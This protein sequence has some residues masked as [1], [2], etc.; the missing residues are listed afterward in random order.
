M[1]WETIEQR[2]WY[3]SKRLWIGLGLSAGLTVLALPHVQRSFREWRGHRYVG[4]AAAASA[5]GQFDEA[6]LNARAALA[7]NARDLEALRVMAQSLETMQSPAAL[8]VRR[9]IDASAPE[10]SENLLGMAGDCLKAGDAPG[11][12]LA[13]SRI[14]PA[15]RGQA[16]YYDAQAGIFLQRGLPDQADQALSEAVKL[17]PK[18]DDYRLRQAA[19][20]LRSRTPETR[21]EALQT[22]DQLSRTSPRRLFALRTLLE[23]AT[24]HGDTERAQVLAA[25]VAADPT[26]TFA[27]RLVRLTALRMRKGSAFTSYSDLEAKKELFDVLAETQQAAGTK[28]GEIADLMNWMN[29]HDLALMVPDWEAKLPAGV[30]GKPPVGIVVAEA[31]AKGSAWPA[32]RK[33]LEKASWGEAEFLRLAYLA[34]CLEWEKEPGAEALWSKAVTAA[35]G[36]AGHLEL[37]AKTALGWD[38]EKRAGEVLWKLAATDRCPRWALDRLWTAAEKAQDSEQLYRVSKLLLHADPKSVPVRNSYIILALLTGHDAESS[39]QLAASLARENPGDEAVANTY[40]FSLYKEGKAAEAVRVMDALTPAQLEKPPVA[41]YYGI[42]LVAAGQEE[43]AGKYLELGTKATQLPEEKALSEHLRL[44]LQAHELEK[45]GSPKGAEEAWQGALAAAQKQPEPLDALGK[46]ALGWGWT[47]RAEAVALRL[48][49]GDRCPVW[50][51]EPLWSAALRSADSARLYKAAR[52]IWQADP[53]NV[54]ARDRFILLALL[55]RHEADAPRRLAEALRKE[56]PDDGEIA[57]AHG[58][59][60]VQEGKA[61]EAVAQMKRLQPEQLRAPRAALYYGICLAAAGQADKAEQYLADGAPAALFPE[62]KALVEILKAAGQGHEAGSTSPGWEQ[63]VALAEVRPDWL[64]MLAR[65]A[66]AR[67]STDQAGATLWKLAKTKDCPRWA[68]EYLWKA[69]NREA[70]TPHLYEA[71]KLL[72]AADPANLEAR[73][74]FIYLSLLMHRESDFPNR[75]AESLYRE[76][77]TNPDVVTTFGLSLFQQGRTKEAIASMAA[78]KA[79]QLKEPKAALYYGVFLAASGKMEEAE[80]YFV[81]GTAAAQF[82]EEKALV[83]RARG[84]AGAPAPRAL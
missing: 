35:Q 3:Q 61:E 64:E 78:L 50:A 58:L 44:A 41:L 63:A 80:R 70:D 45:Q 30:T 49:D 4:R 75:Y 18:V 2:A 79:D 7:L 17:D 68:L 10:D 23:D 66:M 8:Q 15:E 71:S 73:T 40:G 74:R 24:A 84:G 11:A 28:A 47:S 46:L 77:P 81:L 5:R 26:A 36:K 25:T 56:S 39:H 13:L 55:T 6:I 14:K 57:A 53:K 9:Q 83:A 54:P 48:A 42:F 82:P 52:L 20:R 38:W 1:S 76:H 67:G 33:R 16:R 27:E 43:K 51:M 19:L 59:A 37:L 21:A 34:R 65:M 72:S 22:L 31:Y 29:T 12:E 60:L 69:A 32:L 62:E